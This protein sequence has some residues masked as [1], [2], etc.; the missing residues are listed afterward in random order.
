MQAV[1]A[2]PS[3]NSR[4][5]P[6]AEIEIATGVV[7]WFNDNDGFGFFTF[8]DRTPTDIFVHIQAVERA[9]LSTL[10][11]GDRFE[12]R[13]QYRHKDQKMFATHLNQI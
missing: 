11:K 8:D 3:T 12:F 10:R 7:K 6:E 5:E 4:P 13:I 2:R 9:G 1:Q